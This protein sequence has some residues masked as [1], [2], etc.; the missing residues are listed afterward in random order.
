MDLLLALGWSL[1]LSYSGVT[2]KV[3]VLLALPSLM[4]D[5]CQVCSTGTPHIVHVL[6]EVSLPAVVTSFISSYRD[7]SETLMNYHTSYS[8]HSLRMFL[9]WQRL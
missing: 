1:G 4:S 9:T 8:R 5:A 6:S 3:A 7:F 2:Y